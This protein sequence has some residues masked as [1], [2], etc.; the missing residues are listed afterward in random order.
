MSRHAGAFPL[1]GGS[2]SLLEIGVG[3]SRSPEFYDDDYYYYYH[4]CLIIIS[5]I[6]SIVIVFISCIS[7]IVIVLFGSMCSSCLPRESGVNQRILECGWGSFLRVIRPAALADRSLGRGFSRLGA[8][9]S[10][11]GKGK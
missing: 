1:H 4:F 3:S 9:G 5:V 6:I 8:G 2:P 11:R 10:A 7:V